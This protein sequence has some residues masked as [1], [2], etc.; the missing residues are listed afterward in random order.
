MV[1]Y[2]QLAVTC[3][4]CQAGKNLNVPEAIFAQKKFGTIKIQVPPG[5]VC[6]NHQF[7]VFVDT[8]GIIRGYEKIDIHMSAPTKEEVEE[9]RITIRTFIQMLGPEGLSS[10]IH[11]K[12]FAYPAYI[13]MGPRSEGVSEELINQIG[14]NILPEKYRGISK[15]YY[16]DQ[17]EDLSKLKMKDKDSLLIDNQQYIL[18]TPWEEKLKWEQGIINKALE[19]IDDGE[20]LI[21]L[22]QDIARLAKEAEYV[23][24]VLEGEK[25]IYEDDLIE[26]ISRDLMIPKI[27]HYRVT[28]IKDFIRRRFDSKLPNKIKNKV[29][30]FL[31]LL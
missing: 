8:K 31:G 2:K 7:I 29:E 30:E 19:I 20:Q 1:E 24:K 4:F 16:V 11:A 15:V 18:K 13:Q 6:P 22:Q 25:E 26:R 21:I 9:G 17:G 28:L 12:T 10:L 27:N 23:K 14:E 3:P 5:A